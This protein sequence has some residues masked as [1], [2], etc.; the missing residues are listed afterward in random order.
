[1][2][3]SKTGSDSDIREV[4]DPKQAQSA[5]L[6]PKN[7]IFCF[8]GTG[9]EPQDAVQTDSQRENP[10]VAGLS[11][12]AKL[13]LLFG[14]D[15]ERDAVNEF[16]DMPEQISLYYSGVGTYGKT[17][18]CLINTV[19]AI[20]D[21]K[22]ILDWALDDLR[23]IYRPGD[24]I[25]VIGFSRGAAIARRFC[26]AMS[27][28]EKLQD[29]NIEMLI[30]FDTIAAIGMPDISTLIRPKS[31]VVFENQRIAPNIVQALHCTS[32][33][34]KRRG[35]QPTLMNTE[36]RVTEVWFAGAHSDVGGGY[37]C[38]H[39]LADVVLQFV[40]DEIVKRNLGLKVLAPKKV[41]R[42]LI[43][44]ATKG[45]SIHMDDI[46]IKPNPRDVSHEQEKTLWN[47]HRKIVVIREDKIV[48]DELPIVH[49][50][51]AERIATVAQYRPK[52]LDHV[53]HKILYSDGTY[54]EFKGLED[55]LP[56]NNEL[57]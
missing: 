2:E 43:S 57:P 46:D 32:I 41:K 47:Y 44:D 1:M 4:R 50:S 10:D 30:A 39:G 54:K 33:D 23:K 52:N 12:V 25:F 29:I 38:D 53:R 17:P 34:D 26:S 9:N 28:D 16:Y 15:F 22:D 36:D 49:H 5:R 7:T 31:K 11:N 20:P 24:K 14:G 27:Q 3:A 56:S 19:I 40:L 37:F 35:F 6:L 55:H 18:E 48:R 8:D 42:V 51:V 21:V 13:H 45:V